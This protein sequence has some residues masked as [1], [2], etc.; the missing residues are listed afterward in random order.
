MRATWVELRHNR[1]LPAIQ[2]NADYGHN[3]G[4]PDDDQRA[5]LMST[6][7]IRLPVRVGISTIVPAR[8]SIMIS[9]SQKG[10]TT[11]SRNL[12]R[13]RPVQAIIPSRETA[14]LGFG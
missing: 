7:P 10:R 14:H 3:Q 6:L 5:D 12:N 1:R 4:E 13:L 9:S 8:Q 11:R 2:E